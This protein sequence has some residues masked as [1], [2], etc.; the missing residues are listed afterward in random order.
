M[1]PGEEALMRIAMTKQSGKKNKIANEL[2]II[3]KNRLLMR[4]DN[5]LL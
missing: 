5:R 2:K 4:I 3:S 1:G